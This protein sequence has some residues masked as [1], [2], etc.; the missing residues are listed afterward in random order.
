[1]NFW[2]SWWTATIR[3][4]EFELYTPWW[5][6]GMSDDSVSICA[7]VHATSPQAAEQVIYDAY[8]VKP[9]HLDFRFCVAH[10]DDW[11]PFNS[12]FRRAHW[13]EW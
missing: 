4:G 6:S 10:D 11:T 5:R 13:M 3:H 12:R 8:D 2:I 1:M 7:A 9:E